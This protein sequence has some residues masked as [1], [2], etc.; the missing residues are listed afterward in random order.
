M[1]GML[2]GA[3]SIDDVGVLR[4]GAKAYRGVQ[5]PST[6]GGFL[7]GSP[8][9]VRQLQSGCTGVHLQPGRALQP[10]AGR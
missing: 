3:D 8:G 6:L 7:R 4:H 2:A 10:A 9:D 5:A 1:A